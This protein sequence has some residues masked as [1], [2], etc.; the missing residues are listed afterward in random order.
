V[1]VSV[2][3]LEDPVDVD[4]KVIGRLGEERETMLRQE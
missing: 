2:I 3:V 4:N 1:E